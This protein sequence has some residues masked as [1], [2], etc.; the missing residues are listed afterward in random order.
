MI[1]IVEYAKRSSIGRFFFREYAF[2][3]IYESEV[4]SFY[5]KLSLEVVNDGVF[6]IEVIETSGNLRTESLVSL[7][8]I[9]L[10][11]HVCV[12]VTHGQDT[13]ITPIDQNGIAIILNDIADADTYNAICT[14]IA[15]RS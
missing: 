3:V 11:D 15:L 4:S 6:N 14:E 9:I 8:G 1:T 13:Q 2:S 5:T 7:N 12:F 10:D